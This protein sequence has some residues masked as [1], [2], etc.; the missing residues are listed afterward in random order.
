MTSAEYPHD[1]GRTAPRG[2]G[3]KL[4]TAERKIRSRNFQRGKN[5]LCAMFW[6]SEVLKATL[7]T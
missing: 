2:I 5:S 4:G 7:E 6:G 1:Y 3:V